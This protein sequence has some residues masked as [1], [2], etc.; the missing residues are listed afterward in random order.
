MKYGFVK[1]AAASPQLKVAD[2]KF[3]T[4]KIEEEIARQTKAGTEILV[5]PELSLCGYTCGDLFLQPLLIESC[6]AALKEITDF[7]KG[8]SMLV[9]VGLPVKNA[10]KL[11][12]CAAAVCDGKVLGIV[13]KTHIPNYSEF[14]ELRHF[15]SAPMENSRVCLWDEDSAETTGAYAAFGT[16]LLFTDKKSPEIKVACEICEDLWVGDPPSTRHAAAGATIVVNLS[17][18]DETIGK[19]DYRRLLVKSQSGKNI[20]AY[21]YA[22]AGVGEST[23][24]MVFSGHNLIAEN[25]SIIAESK[26]FAGAAASAEIDVAFLAAE[27]Q[28]INTYQSRE[29]DGLYATI[30]A[31]FCGEGE[32]SLRKVSRTPFV[33]EES[34]LLGE[35]VELILSSQAHALAK[36]LTH[37]NA[38]T[39]VIGISGG[40]DSSLALLVTARAF[41]LAGKERK[42]IVAVTMPGFGTT[43]K[44][45]RNSLKLIDCVGASGRSIDIS[46]SVLQ[47]FEDIGHARDDLDVTYENAQARM[48]TLILMDLANKTGG[49]VIG[50][51]D[52]SELAL[53]WCTYNGD[54]MSMYAVN[55]SVP[56][57]LVKHLVRYEGNKTGGETQAVLEEILNTEI[58]PELLPPD[59]EGK[60]VQKTEDIVGPYELHDFY[61]YHAIRC[62]ET[63]KKVYYLANY[64]FAGK[65]DNVVLLKWLKNFYR[66]FFSQQFKRSCIPDGVKI[67]SVTLSPRADWRMPSDASAAL[68]LAELESLD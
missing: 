41:D 32:L 51:G 47:H 30:G 23:T 39:A 1:V 5:F 42:D 68:W 36:R 29:N 52:L 56:K 6:R 61:L 10:G 58:S 17:A 26:P 62:G 31:N 40:L 53:G 19:A 33:P 67:G 3:N 27:R 57:T 64:A 28:K 24:E 55:S 15:A 60:I 16:A 25:G 50:T 48:R 21:V 13:P 11:Y 20:C 37:T 9:F 59:K 7:T 8:I 34:V 46:K 66:R 63:P 54:H 65:Y 49:L 45:Y 44:T 22:D 2:V 38:K 43:G 12:N 4:L 14:Y 18:S 35:R